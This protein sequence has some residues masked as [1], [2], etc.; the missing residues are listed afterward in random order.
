MRSTNSKWNTAS[1]LLVSDIPNALFGH[2]KK[3]QQAI[4]WFQMQTKT[5]V[6]ASHI[7]YAQDKMLIEQHDKK[8]KQQNLY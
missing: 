8:K 6:F 7:Y 4:A 1:F 5:A 2:L 3:E